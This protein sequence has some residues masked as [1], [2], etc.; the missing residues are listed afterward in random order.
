M[1][2]R[3]I[4]NL[5]TP[6]SFQLL[7]IAPTSVRN[8][9]IYAQQ[10]QASIE[11]QEFILWDRLVIPAEK[12]KGTVTN[13]LIEITKGEFL[14]YSKDDDLDDQTIS[15]YSQGVILGFEP[16][17]RFFPQ[18]IEFVETEGNFN[19]NVYHDVATLLFEDFGECGFG[20]EIYNELLLVSIAEGVL[21]LNPFIFEELAENTELHGSPVRFKIL[22]ANLRNFG[23]PHISSIPGQEKNAIQYGHRFV[24]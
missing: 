6:A 16:V 14:V 8:G 7:D 22:E 5:R 15:K 3:I 24:D 21:A 12:Y 20:F 11:Q 10:I 4:P 23:E 17:Y 18:L 9:K 2:Q 13:C 1:D 19:E